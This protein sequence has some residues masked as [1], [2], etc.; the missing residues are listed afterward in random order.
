MATVAHLDFVEEHPEEL[1]DG[2][3]DLA[4]LNRAF[5]KAVRGVIAAGID[6]ATFDPKWRRPPFTERMRPYTKLTAHRVSRVVDALS[7]GTPKGTAAEA[8]GITPQALRQW[9]SKGSDALDRIEAGEDVTPEEWLYA[10]TS[11]ALDRAWSEGEQAHFNVINEA[12]A[13]EGE[14]K[15]SL[16]ILQ[17]TRKKK[18]AKHRSI[19]R[20]VTVEGG[21]KLKLDVPDPPDPDRIDGSHVEEL[22]AEFVDEDMLSDQDRELLEERGYV[23]PEETDEDDDS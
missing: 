23:L 6:P 4:P 19:D 15:A 20:N 18:Y 21:V 11:V 22:A 12:A 5:E 3:T 2:G 17:R 16:E 1:L 9:W 13:E 8:A 7:A 10:A 14:W